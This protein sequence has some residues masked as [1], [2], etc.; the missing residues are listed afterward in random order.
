MCIEMPQVYGCELRKARKTHKCCEC[1]GAIQAGEKYHYHHGVWDGRA[2]SFKVCVECESLRV[3]A[4]SEITD[5][6]DRTPFGGLCET[7]GEMRG[8]DLALTRRYIE[9]ALRRGAVVPEWLADKA[10]TENPTGQA[11]ATA[12]EKA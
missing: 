11:T 2:E 1:R 3:E 8:N 5:A 12:K 7:M 9:I 10:F 6:E 4:D